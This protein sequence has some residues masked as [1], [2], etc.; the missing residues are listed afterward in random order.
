MLEAA[1]RASQLEKPPR[2]MEKILSDSLK[3]NLTALAHC[4]VLFPTLP[5]EA[6]YMLRLYRSWPLPLLQK[7][8]LAYRGWKDRAATPIKAE[9]TA[10]PR[11]APPDQEIATMDDQI[12]HMYPAATPE[13]VEAV[14]RVRREILGEKNGRKSH[15]SPECSLACLERQKPC[16]RLTFC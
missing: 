11:Q 13:V 9:A 7:R 5:S 2:P 10:A 3:I 15:T 12:R 8:T 4:R 16:Q 6:L 1:L 14:A